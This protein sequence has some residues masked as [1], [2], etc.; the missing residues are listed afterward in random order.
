MWCI[1]KIKK[2]HL[3]F[4]REDLT[5]KFGRELIF[6]EPKY[7][8]TV[9]NKNRFIKKIIRL[10][11]NHIFVNFKNLNLTNI[12]TLRFIKGSSFF[13]ENSLTNQTLIKKFIL[14]CKNFED[15]NG[16]LT[17]N[18]FSRLNLIKDKFVSGPFIDFFFKIINQRKEN[19]EILVEDKRVFIN[20][21]KFINFHL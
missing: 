3:N 1:F 17:E 18:F 15:N 5:N 20:K 21:K 9:L 10:I 11:P 16:Y 19:F 6:Y 13:Y 2:N 4:F 7:K 8:K 12:R 14:K